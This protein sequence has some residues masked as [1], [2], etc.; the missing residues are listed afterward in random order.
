MYAGVFVNPRGQPQR[1]E[2]PPEDAAVLRLGMVSPAIG[3]LLFCL[4]GLAVAAAL[5][6]RPLAVVFVAVRVSDLLNALSLPGGIGGVELV[7]AG[8]LVALSGLDVAT[9]GAVAF[10][11]RLCTYWFVLLL[12][13]AATAVLSASPTR[14]LV[15]T[16][17]R[18]VA[19]LLHRTSDDSACR[20]SSTERSAWSGTAR[21]AGLGHRSASSPSR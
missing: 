19:T 12:G 20:H 2:H 7:L 17:L 5:G 14:S 13:G 15:P 11:F 3:L 9:A 4:T 8:T 1:L 10:A 21:S 6:K 18:L 16:P